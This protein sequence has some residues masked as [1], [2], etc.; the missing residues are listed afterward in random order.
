MNNLHD[1][2]VRN[3]FIGST[4]NTGQLFYNYIKIIYYLNVYYF[5]LTQNIFCKMAKWNDI[6]FNIRLK[7]SNEVI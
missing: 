6:C 1:N 3:D 7:K 4:V 5:D 2:N